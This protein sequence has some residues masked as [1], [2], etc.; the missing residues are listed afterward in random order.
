MAY[1]DIAVL[2]TDQ[3]FIARIAACYA[4]ETLDHIGD[5]NYQTAE[6]WSQLNAMSMAAQP[7][8]GGAYAYALNSDP[9]VE[10][11]GKNPA[12]ITDAQI[13]VGCSP[14]SPPSPPHSPPNPPNDLGAHHGSYDRHP[15]LASLPS[16][17]RPA[18]RP[19]GHQGS[20]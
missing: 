8:F 4:I 14:C 3:D 18:Q 10:H 13:S 2:S 1:T 9:P 17:R 16:R 5:V 7:G 15:L 12:V 20:R 6:T 19:Q 11:P